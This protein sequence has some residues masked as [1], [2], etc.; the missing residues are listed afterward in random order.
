MNAFRALRFAAIDLWEESLVLLMVGLLGGLAALLVL[1]LPFVLAA[2]YGVAERIPEHRVIGWRV[3]F[4]CGREHAR[5]FY[6]WVLLLFV[7]SAVLLT[8]AYFY[9]QLGS[10]AAT[11]LGSIT[12]GILLLWWLPQPFVPALYLKQ[13]DRRLRI[14]LRN[15]TVLALRDPLSPILLWFSALLLAIPLGYVAWPLLLLLLVWLAL[16]STRAVWLHL[17]RPRTQ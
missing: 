3:W 4:R 10:E 11:I 9:I 6:K 7:V 16:V 5:F 2:H 14:A 8:S 17:K 1:P 15:A 12:G 13:E